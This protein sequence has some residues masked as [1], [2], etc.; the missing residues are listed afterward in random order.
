MGEPRTTGGRVWAAFLEGAVRPSAAGLIGTLVVCIGLIAAAAWRVTPEFVAGLEL[1]THLRRGEDPQLLVTAG[2][3]RA[4]ARV[5]HRRAVGV[6]GASAQLSAMGTS[7]EATRVFSAEAGGEVPVDVLCVPGLTLHEMLAVIELCEAAFPGAIVIGVS[8]MA[9]GV[10]AELDRRLARLGLLEPTLATGVYLFDQWVFLTP[11]I[12]FAL[13]RWLRHDLP[14]IAETPPKPAPRWP[15]RVLS[16]EEF[17]A[18][19][20]ERTRRFAGSFLRY[21]RPN[22]SLR[23]LEPAI[24]RLRASGRQVILLE[25]QLHPDLRAAL[26]PDEWAAYATRMAD[27]AHRR[28]AHY[29]D[30]HEEA[31]LTPAD[32]ADS[33]HIATADAR[34]RYMRALT[35]RL[36]PLLPGEEASLR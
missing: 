18:D 32:F 7:E 14:L 3:L 26:D 2:V 36:V 35:R 12:E 10:D 33:G 34:E 13:R 17:A 27:L 28:G 25:S 6:F 21:R 20:E 24:E 15:S 30:L 29:W 22:A 9:A 4:R 31:E 1:P 8:S 19:L 23:L 5:P 16:P 11:R